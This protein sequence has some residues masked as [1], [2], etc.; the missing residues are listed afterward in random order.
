MTRDISG[1]GMPYADR[2]STCLRV[3]GSGLCARRPIGFSIRQSF[4]FDRLK[5]A[6]IAVQCRLLAT[7]GLPALD[8]HI[9]VL[10]EQ[11]HRVA[12]ATG[13]LGSNDGCSGTAEWFVHGLTGRRV[14]LDRALHAHDGLLR[15]VLEALPFPRRD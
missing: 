8:S 15:P 7:E 9:H 5:A 13:N 11:L 3:V 14:I 10:R 4:A 2:A 1:S 6:A 12:R